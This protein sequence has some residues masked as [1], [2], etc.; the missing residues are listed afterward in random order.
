MVLSELF[1]V[2]REYKMPELGEK[3][4]CNYDYLG[5]PCSPANPNAACFRYLT[6]SEDLQKLC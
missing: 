1:L 2:G 3:K 5:S 6:I 4:S